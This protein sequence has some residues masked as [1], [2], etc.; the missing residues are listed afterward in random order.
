MGLSNRPRQA[1]GLQSNDPWYQPGRDVAYIYQSMCSQAFAWLSEANWEEWFGDYLKHHNITEADLAEGCKRFAEGHNRFTGDASIEH[2]SD[3]LEQAGFLEM[4]YPV[5]ITMYAL[6][7]VVLT[8]TFFNGVRDVTLGGNT[9][10]ECG[11]ESIV[12]M[13]RELLERYKKDSGDSSETDTPET[14]EP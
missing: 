13:G 5:Q 3:A 14:S 1:K 6:L 9:P 4:P 7:G 11:L 12:E 10:E 8:G 2:A